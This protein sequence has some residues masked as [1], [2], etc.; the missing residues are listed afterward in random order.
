VEGDNV[1]DW[2]CDD[3]PRLE[4]QVASEGPQPGALRP[5]GYTGA[6]MKSY[7]EEPKAPELIWANSETLVKYLRGNKGCSCKKMTWLTA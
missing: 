7:G 1:C 5:A 4:G 3:M 2:L 6:Y